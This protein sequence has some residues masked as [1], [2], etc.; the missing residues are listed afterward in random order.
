MKFQKTYN[1]QHSISSFNI[2]NN[3]LCYN[4]SPK[5][6]EIKRKLSQVNLRKDNSQG[7]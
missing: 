6:A 3:N 2:N 1:L 4:K 5:Q 7:L